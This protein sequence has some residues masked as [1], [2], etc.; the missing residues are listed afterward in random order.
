MRAKLKELKTL[1]ETPEVIAWLKT[2]ASDMSFDKSD[3]VE[4]YQRVLRQVS[5]IKD[6]L[7]EYQDLI[8]NDYDL[9]E[10]EIL[11]NNYLELESY[12][13]NDSDDEDELD[14]ID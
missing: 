12:I 9:F 4:T 13:E 5:R 7:K 14:Y 8:H 2:G 11:E 10:E 6:N 1:L 3:Y